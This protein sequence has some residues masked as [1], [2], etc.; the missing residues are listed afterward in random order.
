VYGPNQDLGGVVA[1]QAEAATA[2]LEQAGAAG[3]QHLKTATG[4]DAEF[5]HAAD[6]GRLAGHLGHLGPVAATEQFERE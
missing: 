1:A 2:D 5:G 4:P 3:L 6:P